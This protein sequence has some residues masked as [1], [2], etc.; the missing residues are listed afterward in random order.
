MEY[1]KNSQ[2]SNSEIVT[3]KND[4][5]MNKERYTSPEKSQKVIDNL[6]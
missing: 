6:R 2:Q 3:N 5:E 1:Q 4:K